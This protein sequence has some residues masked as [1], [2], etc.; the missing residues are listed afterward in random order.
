[1]LVNDIILEKH[2]KGPLYHVT[3]I[4]YA[5][6]ILED[7]KIIFTNSEESEIEWKYKNNKKPNNI[8]YLS[9]SRSKLNAFRNLKSI[10]LYNSV[11][12]VIDPNKINQNMAFSQ[13]NYWGDEY[14]A[15]PI[16]QESEERIWSNKESHPIDFIVETHIFQK[17]LNLPFARKETIEL[18]EL[19]EKGNNIPCYIYTDVKQYA[20]LNKR[21]A[22]RMK[23]LLSDENT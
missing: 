9:T 14:G 3:M 18:A 10:D 21:K 20:V 6:D 7:K 5:M 1:M 8:Y 4:S 12:F 19:S 11:T 22:Y 23:D 13:V 2:Y 16:G 17:E 15:Y